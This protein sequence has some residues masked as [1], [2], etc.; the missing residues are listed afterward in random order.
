MSDSHVIQD[1]CGSNDKITLEF[2][3]WKVIIGDFDVK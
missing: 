2:S 1:L 3:K